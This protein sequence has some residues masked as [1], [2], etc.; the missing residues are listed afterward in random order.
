MNLGA[1]NFSSF[2]PPSHMFWKSSI[3]LSS[4]NTTSDV[5]KKASSSNF[6]RVFNHRR[7]L[8]NYLLQ[9]INSTS[10]YQNV[11]NCSSMF[12]KLKTLVRRDWCNWLVFKFSWAKFF[13]ISENLFKFEV[14]TIWLCNNPKINVEFYNILVALLFCPCSNFKLQSHV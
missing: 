1:S 7:E 5:N 8:L 3:Y 9:H 10:K 6:V 13:H 4:G 11:G 12:C 14:L 2:A